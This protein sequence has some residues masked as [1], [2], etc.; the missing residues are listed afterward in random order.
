MTNEQIAIVCHEANRAL[1][2]SFGDFSQKPWAEAEQWQRDAAFQSI[3]FLQGNPDAGDSA[4]HDSWMQ[5]KIKDGW[6]YGE[7]K[8]GEAKT[9]PCL[10]P[11]TELPPQQQA[12][13]AIFRAIV[14]ACSV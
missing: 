14:V 7:K 4:L 8:D 6:V 12:K 10:V 1:C 5:A 9:H 11:F 3:E 13:D 2:N